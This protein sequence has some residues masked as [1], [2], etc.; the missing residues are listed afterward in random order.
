MASV[1]ALCSEL[2]DLA[3]FV[4]V[5]EKISGDPAAK[6]KVITNMIDGFVA[7]VRGCRSLTPLTA[8]NLFT[9]L[10]DV[11]MSTDYKVKIQTAIDE[12]MSGEQ[13]VGGTHRTFI[14]HVPQKLTKQITNYLTTSDWDTLRS[15]KTSV[16][17]R[18]QVIVDRFSRLG[19][20]HPH[21]QTVKWAI[22]VVALAVGESNGVFPSY[23]SI[24][25]MV[26]DFKSVMEASRKPWAFGYLV[27]YPD[28]PADLPSEV[29]AHA[30][31]GSDLPVVQ[32]WDRLAVTAESHVPLR[33][34][35]ALIKKETARTTPADSGVDM[36]WA[37]QLRTLLMQS[38]GAGPPIQLRSSAS[39]GHRPAL[40]DSPPETAN[41]F[42]SLQPQGKKFLALSDR[43]DFHRGASSQSLM[44]ESPPYKPASDTPL[45]LAL[46]AP[47]LDEKTVDVG[48]GV[49]GER[50][51]AAKTAEDYEE[52]AFK[53]LTAR[54]AKRARGG[55]NVCKRPAAAPPAAAKASSVAHKKIDDAVIIPE[56]TKEARKKP[57]RNFQSSAYHGS[58]KKAKELGF[59]EGEA[60]TA[61]QTAYSQAGALFDASK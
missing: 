50:V 19:L 43:A 22:A 30:Y 7:K 48:A 3:A 6:A 14:Q 26:Q 28:K 47:P 46:P 57:R 36:T 55:D 61:A 51:V 53:A 20:M 42:M 21:E 38:V 49:G 13:A 37:D 18:I 16:Q 17:G 59:T 54:G 41:S 9:A 2:K 52:A 31:D 33:K 1:D 35:S 10:G 27:I 15:P 11:D 34:N 58:Y 25:G 56:L 40:S 5:R 8:I 32:V 4:V 29:F 60:K 45:Q 23:G 44:P 24:F 12:R 39:S